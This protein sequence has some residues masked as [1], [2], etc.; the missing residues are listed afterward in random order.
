M[1]GAEGKVYFTL[2]SKLSKQLMRTSAMEAS[3]RDKDTSTQVFIGH[4]FPS[5]TC[6]K[7]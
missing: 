4:I 7:P 5:F 1:M 2:I 6:K 3:E